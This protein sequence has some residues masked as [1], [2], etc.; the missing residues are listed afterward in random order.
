GLA[1]AGS[2]P[3][4]RRS[5]YAAVGYSDPWWG[6][7][8]ARAHLLAARRWGAWNFALEGGRHATAPF[9]PRLDGDGRALL[10]QGLLLPGGERVDAGPVRE[11][12]EA[13]ARLELGRR[14]H[15]LRVGWI[16]REVTGALGVDPLRAAD[17]APGARDTL[18]VSSGLVRY[19]ALSFSIGLRL[20]LGGR[21]EADG[22]LVA[23]PGKDALPV[24]V[25]R[26]HG[27]ALFAIGRTF[28]QGDLQ[29]EGRL[30]ATARDAMATPAGHCAPFT[31]YDAEIHG[32]LVGARFFLAVRNLG[33]RPHDSATYADGA[34]MPLPYRSTQAGVEWHFR[35]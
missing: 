34:W 30:V 27:R 20:P 2:W 4:E 23:R 6:D 29:L 15:G 32:R 3:G 13:E 35:D 8:H 14:S 11:A 18:G 10:E 21:L 24:L 17:L 33:N 12:T 9:T 1:I 22:L 31:R 16:A 25:P 19:Q 26:G 5:L 28:F 7:G